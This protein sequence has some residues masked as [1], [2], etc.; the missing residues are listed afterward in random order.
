MDQTGNFLIDLCKRL[1][2]NAVPIMGVIIFWCIAALIGNDT[3]CL[4]KNVF[5][6]PCPGC[7]MTR[8]FISLFKGNIKQ[9][10]YFHPLFIVPIIIGV[11]ILF[12]NY[13]IFKR[14]YKSKG[15]W[16]FILI[17]LVSVWGIRMVLMF[18]Y[19]APMD[20]NKNAIMVRI[21]AF[22]IKRI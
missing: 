19:E 6:I 20:F 15:F 3:V 21:I 14:A 8:A 13:G 10:F 2:K 16:I 12:K 17:L 5:G 7:G 22:I 1:K 18:P 4:V 9:A 11:V